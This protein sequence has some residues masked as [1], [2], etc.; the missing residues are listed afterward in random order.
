MEKIEDMETE[1][2][3][4]SPTK[5]RL[6]TL[7]GALFLSLAT[8][9]FALALANRT[10]RRTPAPQ[11]ANY[12]R[13]SV[14]SRE[15]GRL[16][17]K[18]ANVQPQPPSAAYRRGEVLVKFRTASLAERFVGVQSEKQLPIIAAKE[19][20]VLSAALDRFAVADA[21][22]TMPEVPDAANVVTFRAPKLGAEDTRRLAQEIAKDPSI[23][24]AEPNLIFQASAQQ[25][26]GGGGGGGG[27]NPP[28]PN[29]PYY[30]STGTWGNSYRDQWGVD[31][32][33]G[34][35]A[36]RFIT[37]SDPTVVAVIDTGL[38]FSH[39]DAPAIWTNV[40]E[41]GTLSANGQDDDGNGFIDDWRGWDFVQ[42]D[43][44]S[45]DNNPDDDH[46]HGTHIAG[47]IAAAWNNGQGVAGIARGNLSVMALK[48]LDEYGGGANGDLARAIYYAVDNGARVINASW[49]ADWSFPSQTLHDAIR[50]A[51]DRNVVFVAAAG[52]SNFDV[53][54]EEFGS[55]P[56]NI[57]E[58]IAVS[59]VDATRAK[60][61][62]SNYG[63][64]IDLA[65]PGVDILSLRAGMTDMFCFMNQVYCSPAT[66]KIVGGYPGGRYYRSDG[67]S[68][69]TPHVSAAAGLLLAKFPAYTVEQ[70]RSAL[71]RTALDLGATGFDATYGYGL[72]NAAA[73]LNENNAAAV[74]INAP[75]TTVA[76]AT[77][78][79]N[80][81]VQNIRD[82]TLAAA[83]GALPSAPAWQTI[84]SGTVS[85][86]L[87]VPWN[88]L[89]LAEGPWTLRLTVTGTNGK[90]YQDNRVV[91]V[92]RLR[93][94]S[95]VHETHL[96]IADHIEIRGTVQPEGFRS[97][98]V[99]VLNSAGDAMSPAI[100]LPA[101]GQQPIE[102]GLIATVDATSLSPDWYVLRVTALR[103]GGAPVSE[104]VAVVVD[105]TLHPGWPQIL[106]PSMTRF[107]HNPLL[108]HLNAADLN[109]D[110]AAELITSVVSSVRVFTHSGGL[111]W[112]R[113]V[114]T[115]T[116]AG[117]FNTGPV[118]GDLT[119]DGQPELAAL[120][121]NG[122]LFVW[123]ADGTPL[124]GF[125]IRVTTTEG[126]LTIADLDADGRNEL[127]VA[128]L[129]GYVRVYDATQPSQ[130]RWVRWVVQSSD[131]V[132]SA[133]S[134]ASVGNLDNDPQHHQEIVVRS[135][136][137][138]S[139][140][141]DDGQLLCQV[142]L[143]GNP[144]RS[145]PVLADMNQDG[146]LEIILSGRTGSVHVFEHDCTTELAGWPKE[147]G[148]ELHTPGVG[149]M[150]GDGRPEVV[151][152]T[153][154]WSETGMY[155]AKA[156]AWQAD[157]TPLAGW[158]VSTTVNQPGPGWGFGAVVMA[159]VDND[160]RLEA[161]SQGDTS[162]GYPTAGPQAF[163]FD[164]TVVPNFRKPTREL[165]PYPSSAPA[166]ADLDGDGLLELAAFDLKTTLYVWG[167]PTPASGQASW[168]MFQQNAEHR[169]TLPIP[170]QSFI[171]V[172]NPVA[173]TYVNG[174]VTVT[175]LAQLSGSITGVEFF[176]DNISFGTDATF[177]YALAWDTSQIGDGPH[178]LSVRAHRAGETSVDSDPV[179]VLVQGSMGVRLTEPQEG[180]IL[181]GA[182]QM[183]AD[184]LL[185]EGVTK[186]EFRSPGI[187]FPFATDTTAPYTGTLDAATFQDGPRQLE[188]RAYRPNGTFVTS[189][190]VNV[191]IANNPYVT[192]TD[193]M[194]NTTVSGI[195]NVTVN[196]WAN[197]GIQRVDVI[198]VGRALLG[199]MTTAPYSVPWNTTT[200][201]N[202]T[203][204]L[205]AYAMRGGG[206]TL[207][208]EARTVI[209]ANP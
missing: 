28:L 97:Y 140:L 206:Q 33:D 180:A 35:N 107:S 105:R 142:P 50:Y 163:R 117:Y 87:T 53:G 88:L 133:L 22:R 98:S 93:I 119:A 58:V 96:G 14:L 174:E 66:T 171:V 46:G 170:G 141:A 54:T 90:I 192:I 109:G 60:A 2:G 205:I 6:R 172:S 101:D 65:A 189:P 64:K 154:S 79:V 16:V 92:D 135:W 67:T 26:E 80:A 202:G 173:Q 150:D 75:L 169:G 197:D 15:H 85:G 41:A 45:M 196:A 121:A 195:A 112:E 188:A 179:T 71:R 190:P 185:P 184:A 118:V 155:R 38:D 110:G 62:F 122:Y 143:V 123:T 181:T 199:S 132:V 167:L 23:E 149:D 160:G 99:A 203:Y 152:G 76:G 89:P 63:Q 159:D 139:V 194:E 31:A 1:T 166:V 148:Q 44:D 108:G 106:D 176:A 146:D 32:V 78:D 19:T 36:W 144:W 91:T 83:P 57:H 69:A 11:P 209:V 104:S 3:T 24:Y 186:V 74:R 168:P 111:L 128:D 138:L 43:D 82:W 9:A 7:T 73:A 137:K 13:S 27:D 165:M 5:V 52:N 204:Q 94:T 56:A 95:P 72:V 29:D 126:T 12:A 208:S 175:A 103:T 10:P 124:D 68:M 100:T 49:G 86:A 200:L 47:T 114:T 177:P 158:P 130:V 147:V 151:V 134:S 183:A 201:P 81:T 21:I 48:G 115:P 207:L 193:P 136:E 113:S 17:S 20:P 153:T 61:S 102:D 4:I 127:I 182:T 178:Q 84:G 164:G 125:P 8:L 116:G 162:I 77:V 129:Y 145:N 34:R 191:T 30:A 51:Y 120:T 40:G 161:L 55:S 157:G 131:V 39:P 25:L 42:F 59:A 156:Y 18:V 198:L 70:V 187:A 37:P